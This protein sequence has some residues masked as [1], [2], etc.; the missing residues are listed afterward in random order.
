MSF[1]LESTA[2]FPDA[3]MIARAWGFDKVTVVPMRLHHGAQVVIRP[4]AG[5]EWVLKHCRVEGMNERRLEATLAA[6]DA[7]GARLD[8]CFIPTVRRMTDGRRVLDFNGNLFYVMALVDGRRPTYRR[9]RELAPVLSA[10]G[11]LHAH[12]EGAAAE[13]SR[14]LGQPLSVSVESLWREQMEWFE[15]LDSKL[16]RRTEDLTPTGR[17]F[18]ARHGAFAELAK[19]ADDWL[20]GRLGKLKRVQCPLVLAHGD[21]YENNYLLAKDSSRMPWLLDLESVELRPVVTDLTVPL[22]TYG[23]THRW[24]ADGLRRMLDVYERERTL[25]PVERDLLLANLMFP[26]QWTRSMHCLVRRRPRQRMDWG[27]LRNLTACMLALP[28][29]RRF[30]DQIKSGW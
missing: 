2:Q 11:K 26:R 15:W 22:V 23:M 4:S 27:T 9:E 1:T 20:R 7:A 18:A 10:L 16:S 25:L 14:A 17:F 13:L 30:I 29:Y 12:G 19:Q 6:L 28:S 3:E 21:S 8:P 5:P 24:P